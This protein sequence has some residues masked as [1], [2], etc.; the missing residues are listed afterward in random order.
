LQDR[1]TDFEFLPID[2]SLGRCQRYFQIFGASD[3]F[4]TASQTNSVILFGH[5]PVSM[6]VSPTATFPATGSIDGVYVTGN[7]TSASAPFLWVNTKTSLGFFS[8]GYTGITI[9]DPLRWAG[10]SILLS[11]EL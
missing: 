7:K 11:G 1:S 8:E 2:V 9:G 4:G 5:F 10:G 6:R 3:F